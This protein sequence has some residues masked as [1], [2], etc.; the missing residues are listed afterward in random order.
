MAGIF[1]ATA[2]ALR[3][4]E[5]ISGFMKRIGLADHVIVGPERQ[6]HALALLHS[7]IAL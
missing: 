7:Y 5:L 6:I 4:G 3:S 1:S 2:N